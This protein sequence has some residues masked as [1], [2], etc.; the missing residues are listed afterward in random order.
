MSQQQ[1]TNDVFYDEKCK[2]NI[3]VLIFQLV[4]GAT[5][6]YK[7]KQHQKKLNKL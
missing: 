5:K 6:I 4:L 3:V 2:R 1:Q 7:K